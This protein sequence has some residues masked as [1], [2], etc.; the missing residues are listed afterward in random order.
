[1]EVIRTKLQKIIKVIYKKKKY[2]IERNKD[3]Q[4]PEGL[5]KPD[6]RREGSK[7]EDNK[8]TSFKY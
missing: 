1:M 3:Q 6:A 4:R 8:M 2:Y 7:A 5:L